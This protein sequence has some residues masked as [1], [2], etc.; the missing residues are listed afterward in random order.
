M[1]YKKALTLAGLIAAAPLSSPALAANGH[2]VPGVE[3]IGGPAVPPPGVYYRGY[4]VHYDIDN[5]RDGQGNKAPG[6]N[7]G[8]VTALANRFIWITDKTFLGANYGMEAIVPLQ[9]TSLNFRGLGVKDSDSGLGDIFIGPVVLGWHGQQWD[10]VFAAGHWF[11]TA[12]YEPT[13]PAS[14]GKGYGTT[15]LTLG[16]SWHFDADKRWSFSALSRY[17]IKTEQDDTDITPGDSWLVEWA[18]SHRLDSG[19]N[20][21]LVGYEAWQLERS[22]G[23]AADKAE[24]HALGAEVGY[25]WPHLGLGL[26]GAYYQEY[27]NE[28]GPEGDLL[29][30]H[31]TKVF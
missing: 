11:D 15:M 21:G 28:A 18:L 27:N 12:S 3:G 7:T 19:L 26:N 1:K 10:A 30:L 13:E 25:F 5:L 22:K 2:Y 8:E 16:G 9:D 4:L 14:I 29:R 20:V 24:K 23:T 31:L 17:E 6:K